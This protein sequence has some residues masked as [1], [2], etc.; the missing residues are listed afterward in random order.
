MNALASS[1]STHSI[2]DNHF[3]LFLRFP[4]SSSFSH[5]YDERGYGILDRCVHRA[6]RGVALK[7]VP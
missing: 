2:D 4:I 5:Q 1:R 7:H 6:H 3:R